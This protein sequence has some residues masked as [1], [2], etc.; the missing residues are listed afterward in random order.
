MAKPTR[1]QKEIQKKYNFDEVYNLQD[2]IKLVKETNTT[3]FDASVD[4]DVSLGVDPKKANQMVRGSVALPHGVGKDVNVLVL[5]TPDKE[6]EAKD[7]GAD[8]VG[9]DEL[10]EKMDRSKGAIK[11]RLKK[12][13]FY[14]TYQLVKNTYKYIRIFVA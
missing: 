1:K 10:I 13:G 11:A 8:H 7:A 4:I 14:A 3:K 5:C 2:G 6:Q 9:L 12:L